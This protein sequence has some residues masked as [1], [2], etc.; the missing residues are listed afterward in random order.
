[1]LGQQRVADLGVEVVIVVLLVVVHVRRR[2]GVGGRHIR[3]PEPR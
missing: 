3:R 1:M 2:H